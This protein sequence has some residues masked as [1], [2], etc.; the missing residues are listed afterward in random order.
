MVQTCGHFDHI[1]TDMYKIQSRKNVDGAV[2]Y[3][4]HDRELSATERSGIWV[5]RAAKMLGLAEATQ[6]ERRHILNLQQPAVTRGI[7]VIEDDLRCA[8]RGYA[9][10]S[11]DH[12]GRPLNGRYMPEGQRKC[13]WDVVLSPHKSISVAALCLK[14]QQT[15]QAVLVR[16][17]YEAA[18]LEAGGDQL[19]V[20]CLTARL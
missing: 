10:P 13:A 9:P 20:D 8:L 14:G 6:E 19:A 2:R 12:R 16:A 1:A 7:A 17:A 4:L 3:F 18:T 11:T 5:G 15:E